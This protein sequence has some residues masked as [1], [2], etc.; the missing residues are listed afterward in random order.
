MWCLDTNKLNS[1]TKREINNLI[2]R[3][4]VFKNNHILGR[5]VMNPT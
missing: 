3:T 5:K 1:G 4:R 2:Y